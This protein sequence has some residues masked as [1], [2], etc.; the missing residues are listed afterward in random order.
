MIDSELNRN[1]VIRVISDLGVNNPQVINRYDDTIVINYIK[2]Y[3]VTENIREV[4]NVLSLE[5]N[6]IRDILGKGSNI[7][8]INSKK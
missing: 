1:Q 8:S 3:P 7:I 6:R 2:N 5:S 4:I